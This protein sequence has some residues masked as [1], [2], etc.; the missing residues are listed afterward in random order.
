MKTKSLLLATGLFLGAGSMIAQNL[1]KNGNF[2][3]TSYV[4]ELDGVEYSVYTWDRNGKESN[5]AQNGMYTVFMPGW[6]RLLDADGNPA[7]INYDYLRQLDEGETNPDPWM[8]YNADGGN[9]WDCYWGMT[10]HEGIFSPV[11]Q[12]GNSLDP[13]F[14]NMYYLNIRRVDNDGWGSCARITQTINVEPGTQYN[15]SFAYSLPALINVKNAE[16]LRSVAVYDA[17]DEEGEPLYIFAIEEDASEVEWTVITDN[18]N[19][20]ASCTQIKLKAGLCGSKNWETDN[21]TNNGTELRVDNFMIWKEGTD[22]SGNKEIMADNIDIRTINGIIRIKGANA[23]D[24]LSIFNLAGQE[25]VKETI[26]SADFTVSSNL[27]RGTYIVKINN[28]TRKVIL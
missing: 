14:D 25:V 28:A 13:D 16:M 9:K 27:T 24:Q 22:P 18:F 3:A 21:G 17:A 19:T 6:D 5:S 2:E 10:E 20:S 8:I 1:V 26:S 7:A 15:I 4:D 11:D 23:G 12:D